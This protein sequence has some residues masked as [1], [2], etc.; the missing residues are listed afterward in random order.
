M[1]TYEY[2]LEKRAEKFMAELSKNNYSKDN[3]SNSML[4]ILNK[5]ISTEKIILPRLA[6]FESIVPLADY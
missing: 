1:F 2:I 3:N 5:I 6:I 4:N